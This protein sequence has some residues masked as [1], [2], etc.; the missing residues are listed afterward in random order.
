MPRLTLD[1]DRTG[2]VDLQVDPLE[3]VHTINVAVRKGSEGTARIAAAIE[4]LL[5]AAEQRC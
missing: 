3:P 5:A 2:V 4:A 1:K